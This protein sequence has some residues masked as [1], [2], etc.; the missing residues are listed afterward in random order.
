MALATKTPSQADD[1]SHIRLNSVGPLIPHS[2]VSSF[3]SR[4]ERQ[5]LNDLREIASTHTTLIIAH[6][7]STV[8]HA[9]EIVVLENGTI[10]ERGTH[11]ELP[12]QDG[13]YGALWRAQ[14]SAAGQLEKA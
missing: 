14:Q 3:D 6:R 9:D 8:V 5:I 11:L 4:T 2:E 1:A 7:L 12:E 10:A 13:R